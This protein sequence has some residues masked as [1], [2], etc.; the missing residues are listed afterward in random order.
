MRGI[1][2]RWDAQFDPSI[3]Q[4]DDEFRTASQIEMREQ[5]TDVFRPETIK[6][7]L[8]DFSEVAIVQGVE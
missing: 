2:D 7:A 1:R 6:V 3:R 4:R 5:M 8:I